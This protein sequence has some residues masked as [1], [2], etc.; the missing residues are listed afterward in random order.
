MRTF[1]RCLR[2]TRRGLA[3]AACRVAPSPLLPPVLIAHTRGEGASVAQ[4]LGEW[5]GTGATSGA[6]WGCRRVC[7]LAAGGCAAWCFRSRRMDGL[8]Q[9]E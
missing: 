1:H 2:V 4:A 7:T 5:A 3:G 9:D 6:P 8:E